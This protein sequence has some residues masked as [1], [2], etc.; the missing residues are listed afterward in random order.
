MSRMMN[1]EEIERKIDQYLEAIAVVRKA[2]GYNG[3]SD[4]GKAKIEALNCA[5]RCTEFATT[6]EEF[7]QNVNEAD[8]DENTM[9][10]VKKFLKNGLG[11]Q[12]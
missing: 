12:A 8:A 10:L 2:I 11:L 6:T 9:K 7:I 4:E 1:F 5:W 3:F